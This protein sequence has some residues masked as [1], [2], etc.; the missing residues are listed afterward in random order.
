[1][2]QTIRVLAAGISKQYQASNYQE[3]IVLGKPLW[4]LD[5]E[6]AEIILGIRTQLYVQNFLFTRDAAKI[7]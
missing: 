4:T 7:S 5:A 3:A 2:D 6:L 1:V